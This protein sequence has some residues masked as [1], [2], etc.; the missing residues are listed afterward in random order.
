MIDPALQEALKARDSIGFS[1]SSGKRGLPKKVHYC[2][3]LGYRFRKH[4]FLCI[5][6]G[7]FKVCWSKTC[8]HLDGLFELLDSVVIPPS[9]IKSGRYFFTD[10]RG[11]RVEFLCAFCFSNGFIITSHS[12]ETLS[13][14]LMSSGV[15]RVRGN[16]EAEFLVGFG[17]VPLVIEVGIGQGGVS[18]G[19]GIVKL[20]CLQGRRFCLWTSL[21]CCQAKKFAIQD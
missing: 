8:V 12:I 18:F 6:I 1:Q 15:I 16:G 21:G 5:E 11:E 14:P 19:E 9:V 10:G 7:Q 13:V 4:L 3:P 2:L 17:K 20:Q